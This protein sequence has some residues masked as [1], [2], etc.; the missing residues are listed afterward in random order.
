M[1]DQINDEDELIREILA[2]SR[3]IA[4]VGASPNPA[5]PSH[6]V[7]RYLIGKGYRVF[8]INPGH[9]GR[10]IAGRRVFARLADVPEPIDMVDVFRRSDAVG[11]V[12]DEALAL[13]P[14]PKSVWMQVGVV[15]DEAATRARSAGLKVV[16]DRCPL[17]EHP[18]L[19]GARGRPPVPAGG[20]ASPEAAG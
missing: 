20:G 18:R 19:I 6:G 1:F 8:P 10:E 4:V 15:N 13:M 7:L 5:R 17:I 12:V 16:M 2:E 9:A 11:P 3:T 14:R